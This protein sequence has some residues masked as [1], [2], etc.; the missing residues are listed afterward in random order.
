[1]ELV[2][3]ILSTSPNFDLLLND[4][5]YWILL[6]GSSKIFGLKVVYKLLLSSGLEKGKESFFVILEGG[7]KGIVIE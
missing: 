5:N 1:M 4:E 7:E 3:A 2:D 6:L